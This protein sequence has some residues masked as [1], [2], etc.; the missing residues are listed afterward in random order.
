MKT[1]L[2]KSNLFCRINIQ[3][4]IPHNEFVGFIADCVAGQS[5]WNSV[6][7]ETLDI[8][9]DT[10]DS[11]D[12]EKSRTGKDRWLYFKYTLEIDPIEGV[13]RQHYIDSI[14]A[15]LESLWAKRVEAVA[16]CDFE[17]LLPRNFRRMNWEISPRQETDRV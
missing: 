9:V 15:F 4:A 2:D 7:N 14:A 8:P 1:N 11:Y 3:S 13:L 17:E 6:T 16:S 12:F 5:R 10:N